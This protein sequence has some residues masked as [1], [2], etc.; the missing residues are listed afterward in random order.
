MFLDLLFMR[1]E[2]SNSI[3]AF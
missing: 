2:L 3:I 1:S